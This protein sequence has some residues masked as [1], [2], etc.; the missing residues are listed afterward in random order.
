MKIS[1]AMIAERNRS[2]LENANNTFKTIVN[3]KISRKKEI[4][5]TAKELAGVSCHGGTGGE[6]N[7]NCSYNGMEQSGDQKMKQISSRLSCFK[8]LQSKIF[9]NKPSSKDQELPQLN[10]ARHC[11]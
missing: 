1:N 10:I 4:I 3:E 9:Q 8:N 5:E 11:S 6:S 7:Y 2:K